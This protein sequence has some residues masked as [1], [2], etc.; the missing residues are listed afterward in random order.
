MINSKRKGNRFEQEMAFTFR[1][2]LNWQDCWTSR[3]MGALWQDHLGVDLAGT[4]GYN[5]QCKNVERLSP[6]YHEILAGMPQNKNVNVILHK[7]NNKGVVAVLE[8]DDFIQIIKQN[9]KKG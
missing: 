1:Q 9:E 5:I 6:G 2:Q 3:F 4:P 8:L 7:R